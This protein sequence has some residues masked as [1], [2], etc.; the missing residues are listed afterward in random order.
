[1][2]ALGVLLSNPKPKNGY[3]YRY[4]GAAWLQSAN[5]DWSVITRAV[6]G[7]E[8][9]VGERYIDGGACYVWRDGDG[10]VAQ[11]KPTSSLQ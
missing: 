4:G 10:F 8:H 9:Y 5:D 11:P 6:S 7:A 2:R 1:M 3:T